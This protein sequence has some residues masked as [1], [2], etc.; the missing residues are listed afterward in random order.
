MKL[1]ARQNRYYFVLTLVLFAVGS[2]GLFA[3]IH[4]IARAELD[5]DLFVDAARLR[6]LAAAGLVLAVPGEQ[7]PTT[8]SLT[9][10]RPGPAGLR[11]TIIADPAEAG[12]RTPYRQL[13]TPVTTPAGPQWLTVRRSLL[14]ADEVGLLIVAVMLAVM[15]TLLGALLLVNRW[16]SRRLWRP[17]D[18]TLRAVATY[19]G[20][21]PLSLPATDT[22]EFTALNATLTQMSGRVAHEIEAL[23]EF[24]ENAAHETQTPLAI[25]RTSL[26]QLGQVARLPAAAWPPLADAQAAVR[27]LTRLMQSLTLLSKI[28]NGQFNTVAPPTAAEMS[29]LVTAQ[30]DHLADFIAEKNL[31]LTTQLAPCWLLLPAALAESLVLNLLQNAV[32]HNLPGGVLHVATSAAGVVVRNTGPVPATTPTHFFERFRKHDPTTDSPGLG[33]AIVAQIARVYGL[34]LTYTFEPATTQHVLRVAAAPAPR[35][36]GA[37][38]G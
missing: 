29:A 23:R 9:V 33:L 14:E 11:D 35:G 25:L 4:V 22:D 8:P 26:D 10:V 37:A 38:A 17:L 16:L 5:E 31:R 2:V 3:G 27:R 15:G 20:A 1:L 24:T 30:L 36:V 21:R 19:D 34:T 18:A 28:E 13:T 32:K 6:R 12:E 7:H